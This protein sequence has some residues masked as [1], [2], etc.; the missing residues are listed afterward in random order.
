MA[1]TL[2]IFM[3]LFFPDLRGVSRGSVR[4]FP[5]RAGYLPVSTAA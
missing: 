5:F 2:R 4:C 3:D 1:D